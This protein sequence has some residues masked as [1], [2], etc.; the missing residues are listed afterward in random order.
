MI[1]RHSNFFMAFSLQKAQSQL[2]YELQA[3]ITKQ[4]IKEEEMQIKVVERAQQINVQEQVTT[5]SCQNTPDQVCMFRVASSMCWFR[6][7]A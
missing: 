2:A 3:S 1:S 6:D 4:K 7:N 5:H